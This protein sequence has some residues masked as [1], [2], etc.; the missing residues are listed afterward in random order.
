MPGVRGGRSPRPF[1]PTPRLSPRTEATGIGE[2]PPTAGLPE[3]DAPAGHWGQLA[4]TGQDGGIFRALGRTSLT[5]RGGCSPVRKKADSR[6]DWICRRDRG[7]GSGE[8]RASCPFPARWEPSG[9]SPPSAALAAAPPSNRPAPARPTLQSLTGALTTSSLGHV[10]LASRKCPAYKEAGGGGPALSTCGS[11][12]RRGFVAGPGSPGGPHPAVWLCVAC[13]PSLVSVSP[14]EKSEP[15]VTAHA[16]PRPPAEQGGPPLP[17]APAA[18]GWW[19]GGGP[20]ALLCR[21][22]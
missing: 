7:A 11:R 4:R 9:P 16:R 2:L 3:L 18:G 15:G 22:L 10:P 8:G 13:V 5:G 6:T 21:G 14:S 19:P 17:H 1:P 12:A 20:L